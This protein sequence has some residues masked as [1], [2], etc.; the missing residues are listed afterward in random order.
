MFKKIINILVLSTIVSS[1]VNLKD[2]QNLQKKL[3]PYWQ[4]YLQKDF[5]DNA[6]IE[7]YVATNRLR[8]NADFGCSDE[9][10]GVDFDKQTNYGICMVKVGKMHEIGNISNEQNK[11]NVENFKVALANSTDSKKFFSEIKKTNATPLVFVHGFN[12]RYNEAVLRS[13][14]IAYDLKYQG[15][16]ILYT[17]PAGAKDGMIEEALLNKTYEQNSSNV[18]SSVGIFADFLENLQKNK[19]K[20]NLIVHS[21]GHQL[22]LDAM[23]QIAQKKSEVFINELFLNAPDY[24]AQTFK[25]IVPNLKKLTNHITLYCSQ[26]DKALTVSKI[27]NSNDRL[28]ACSN[29]EQVDVINV[30]AIDDSALGLGHGY[31]SS[32]SILS[33]MFL[34]LIGISP[35]QRLFVAKSADNSNLEGYFLRK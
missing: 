30:S 32:K 6:Q 23:S 16:V 8:K 3:S 31:Y 33:D 24:D 22:V 4:N 26:N 20:V 15:P 10:F 5:A 11:K 12:V 14:Q 34:T 29:V 28:G 9:H 27:F 7:V 21:M 17:W 1:C 19:I 13:A 18:K 25:T 35:K 2:T